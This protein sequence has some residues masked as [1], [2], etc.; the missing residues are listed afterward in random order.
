MVQQLFNEVER[1]K[2]EVKRLRGR[3]DAFSAGGQI[4]PGNITFNPVQSNNAQSVIQNFI[5]NS[6]GNLVDGDVVVLDTTGARRITTTVTPQDVDVLGVVRDFRST[7]PF[8]NA[9]ETPVLLLGNMTGVKVNGAV[10]VG[11]YLVTT[12]SA[13]R[14][15]SV[16][17]DETQAGI[18]GIAETV[19]AA[20][21]GT[22]TASI[23][24]VSYGASVATGS[25]AM[26]PP[27][28][29]GPEGEEGPMGPPGPVGPAGVAGSQGPMGPMGA[30]LWTETDAPEEAMP[31]PG[32]TGATGAQGPAGAIVTTDFYLQNEVKAWPPL[33]E[34]GAGFDLVTNAQWWDDEGTPT[35][36]ATAVP[37]S[38]EAGLDAKFKEVIKCITDA[39]DEGF[40]QRYT[41]ADEPRI[42]S[43]SHI[44]A[45]VWVAT[46]GGGS[47][48]TVK[49]RNSDASETL[50]TSVTTDGDWTLLYV[51]D[52]TCA[53]TYVEL[54]ITKD[55]S[56]TF[57]AGGPIT[58]NIGTSG[59]LLPSR[60]GVYRLN[61]AAN[62][63]VQNLTAQTSQAF[64]DLDLT[65]VTSPLAYRGEFHAEVAEATT[66]QFAYSIR[67]NWTSWTAGVM[68]ATTSV[69][70]K[71]GAE[72]SDVER[73]TNDFNMLM[74]DTQ[75]IETALSNSGGGTVDNCRLYLQGY[76][77]WE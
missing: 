5:N 73:M 62:T 4:I 7:G 58:V 13:T 48:I 1:L 45:L 67:P 9:A 20:G 19:N 66:G 35:T 71:A 37:S 36:K 22:V 43:G 72:P 41:Y 28:I 8:L 21:D 26:G 56:G 59:F 42:K 47:G 17:S 49:L 29:D 11:D 15:K 55:A 14:A 40:N 46:T 30:I 51:E 3:V 33:V 52:H 6:G 69:A 60:K 54:V 32:P 57:Y 64:T 27:G 18:F 53:G 77:E 65:S 39:V 12:N 70:I 68:S 44:S 38:G 24:P 16:A 75:I 50:A 76:W 61:D 10:A 25:G 34:I 63:A 74:D 31:I 23:F 2:A